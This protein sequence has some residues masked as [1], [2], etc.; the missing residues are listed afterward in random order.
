ML[1]HQNDENFQSNNL[2]N[3][4]KLIYSADNL[5]FAT[6]KRVP[7]WFNTSIFVQIKRARIVGAIDA[8][9]P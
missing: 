7:S 8:S 4:I 6:S 1:A 9:D 3:R 2:L 5:G